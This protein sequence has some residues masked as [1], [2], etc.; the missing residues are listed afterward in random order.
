MSSITMRIFF[1]GAAHDDG[2]SRQNRRARATS[3]DLGLSRPADHRG[4]ID[5]PVQRHQSRPPCQSRRAANPWEATEVLEAWRSLRGMPVYELASDGHSTH[6]YGALVPFIQGEIFRWA[7]PNNVSGRLLSLLSALATVTLLAWGMRGDRSA[8]YFGVAW[9]MLLGVNYRSWEYFAEN[10]PDM[11]ALMF[12]ALGLVLLAYGQEARRGWSVVAGSACLVAGFFFK[13]TALIF[14][15]VPLLVLMM[16][17]KRPTLRELCFA[18]LPL[19]VSVGAIGALRLLNPTVYHYMIEVPKAFALRLPPTA[20]NA[21]ELVLDS[22]L[23][24]VLLA[25]WIVV[26]RGSFRKDPRILW[27]MAA[28]VVTIPFSALT[29]AKAGGAE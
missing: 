2:T 27:V 14:S 29:M 26:E 16:R 10:R 28:L 1:E 19:A 8:W 12:S 15:V 17:W 25:E 5:L 22:P 4:G 24:L 6:V 9:A 23:F 11:P 21:W 7:G 13:Q 20:R 18:A 3:A